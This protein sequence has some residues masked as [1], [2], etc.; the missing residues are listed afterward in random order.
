MARD[1]PGAEVSHI[2]FETARIEEMLQLLERLAGGETGLRLPLSRH[3]DHLDALA[4]GVNGIAQELVYAKE[5]A[6]QASQAKTRF[7]AMMSHEI[8]T[9]LTAVLGLAEA[10]RDPSLPAAERDGLLERLQ[11]S[12]RLLLAMVDNVLDLTKIEAGRLEVS[13]EWVSPREVA[14]DVLLA[15]EPLARAKGVGLACHCEAGVPEVVEADP[16]R[17]RQV[18]ANVV[19]NAIKFTPRGEVILR[20]ACVAGEGAGPVLELEVCDTGIGIPAEKQHCLF[21]PFEQADQGIAATYGGTGLGLVIGRRFA[22]LMGGSLRLR[23]S[24]PGVGSVFVLT[25]PLP[26]RRFT[27]HPAGEGARNAEK[28]FAG[29][30]RLAGVRALLAEDSRDLQLVFRRFLELEGAQVTVVAD[31]ALAL[32]ASDR[33]RFDIFL[34]DVNMPRLNGLEATRTLRER[35]FR[36]PILALTAH[37]LGLHEEECREAG[38]SDCLSK[39]FQPEALT[40]TILRLLGR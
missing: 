32:E 25:L 38:Y 15:L 8:R 30:S 37:A 34:L 27:G 33:E 1:A 31:G 11:A 9:P 23:K 13:R 20:L 6:E 10:I 12:G 14:G 22:E 3:R 35:G 28:R 40:C 19:G 2:S 21:R 26:E 29:G 24:S 16:V 4:H 17:L 5:A 39:P 36:Q 18:L 7:L